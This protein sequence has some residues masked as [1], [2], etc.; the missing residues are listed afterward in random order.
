MHWSGLRPSELI[1]VGLIALLLFG[2][3]LPDVFRHMGHISGSIWEFRNGSF[4]R[5]TPRERYEA[6]KQAEEFAKQMARFG[7]AVALVIGVVL[8]T[9]IL[10]YYFSDFGL[11]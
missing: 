10:A 2:R 5:L 11:C 1:I 7:R 3:R 6:E 8:L 4:R 9:V